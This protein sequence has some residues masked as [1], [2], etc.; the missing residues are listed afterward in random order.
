MSSNKDVDIRV[1][2]SAEEK[3]RAIK[4]AARR[5]RENGFE[6]LSAYIRWLIKK[7]APRQGNR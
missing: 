7:D 3:A 5:G 1:R 6:G 4:Q 2:L